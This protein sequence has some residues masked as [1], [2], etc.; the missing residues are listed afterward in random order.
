[1]SALSA[2]ATHEYY[3]ELGDCLP[4]PIIDKPE[5]R[6]R[7]YTTAVEA[8][9]A[10]RPGDAY[11]ARLAV[12]IVLCGAHA[13]DG[14]REAGVHR[15]SFAKMSRCRAQAAGMMREERAAK[16]TLAQ[17]QKVRLAV[18]AVAGTEPVQPTTASAPPPQAELQSAPP[19][20]Q[21]AAAAPQPASMTAPVPAAI[22]PPRPAAAPTS[23]PSAQ[24]GSVPPPSPEAIADAEAFAH[25]NIIAA[26][27]IHHDR[28]V[29]PK[30]KAYLRHL[31]LPIDPAMIDALVRGTSD[32]L[33]VLDE[34]GGEHLGKVA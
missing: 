32:V 20:V 24:A 25:T 5:Y 23:P 21:P 28:G 2:A 10:L 7:R 34:V 33:T 31:T 30:N 27:Q 11:E 15:D 13:V 6:Q 29:T 3:A 8:F 19:P 14:L 9:E 18:A 12:K 16:H 1:M 22:L 4:P 17:E 26:A